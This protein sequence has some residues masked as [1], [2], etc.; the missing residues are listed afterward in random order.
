MTSQWSFAKK[1][2]LSRS[3][4]GPLWQCPSGALYLLL[5]KSKLNDF[6][7]HVILTRQAT[8][9]VEDFFE[10]KFVFLVELRQLLTPCFFRLVHDFQCRRLRLGIISP[11]VGV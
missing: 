6:G 4:W 11:A 3:S 2:L 9:T 8:I 7:T 1:D 5:W 10:K